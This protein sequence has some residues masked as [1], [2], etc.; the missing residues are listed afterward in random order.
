MIETSSFVKPSAPGGLSLSSTAHGLFKIMEGL[1]YQYN[2]YVL[3]L[4]QFIGNQAIYV[5]E[6]HTILNYL[7]DNK[8]SF[9]QWVQRFIIEN[10]IKLGKHTGI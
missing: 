7:R 10:D 6:T 2:F 4:L 1:R 9:K 3:S 8:E 5:D